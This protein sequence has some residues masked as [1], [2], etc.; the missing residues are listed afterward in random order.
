MS[1]E[2][3]WA[4]GYSGN[5]GKQ[6][7]N[8][9]VLT[10]LTT[11]GGVSTRKVLVEHPINDVIYLPTSTDTADIG[12]SIA[13]AGFSTKPD[14]GFIEASSDGE[15]YIRYNWDNGGNS[16]TQAVITVTRK[17]G[18][19]LDGRAIRITGRFTELD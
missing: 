18:G 5:L 2:A 17:D 4:A 1:G 14:V 9:T 13:G 8:A 19:N 3:P 11:G 10:G 15:H 16:S 7:D 12:I 6:N